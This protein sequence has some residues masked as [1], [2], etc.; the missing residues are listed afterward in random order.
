[1]VKHSQSF[2]SL[3]RG[4]RSTHS[5]LDF[6]DVERDSAT[7]WCRVCMEKKMGGK[8]AR[9]RTISSDKI[10]S[11]DLVQ[12][13]RSN[14][15]E[16][17]LALSRAQE[18]NVA[19]Y[20]RKKTKEEKIK[21]LFEGKANVCRSSLYLAATEAPVNKYKKT[22]ELIKAV[23]GKNIEFHKSNR[24]C[25]SFLE[26]AEELLLQSDIGKIRDSTMF[27]ILVDEATS[28]GS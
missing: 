25:F 16:Q 20:F 5:W 3:L 27:S 24:A 18:S 6:Q 4:W 11:S 1:M 17:A 26:A 15:H 7:I 22:L 19:N 28:G 14:S 13:F 12:H 2:L 21:V 9:K 8:W 10:K 23:G